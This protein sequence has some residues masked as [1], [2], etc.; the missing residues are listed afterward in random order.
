MDSSASLVTSEVRLSRVLKWKGPLLQDVLFVSE[1]HA[2]PVSNRGRCA[3]NR[4]EDG[5]EPCIKLLGLLVVC[6]ILNLSGFIRPP[7]ILQLP[8]AALHL[9]T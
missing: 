3:M 8:R 2:I 9:P 5:F 1:E 6:M 4:A 7:S